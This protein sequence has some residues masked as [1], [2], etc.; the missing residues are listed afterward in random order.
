MS[1]T[2]TI[3]S[4]SK[5][6]AQTPKWSGRCFECGAWG[7]LLEEVKESTSGPKMVGKPNLAKPAEIIDL[8]LVKLADFPRAKTGIGEVDRVLGGGIVSGSLI[9]ISGE[10]GIGKSTLIAQI[11]NKLSGDVVYA[12]GEESAHQVKDRLIR[13]GC[14]LKKIKFIS[15]TNLNKIIAAIN[16]EEVDLLIIDS[17]QTVYTTDVEN[18]IG[19]INQIKAC[20]AKLMELAKKDNVPVVIVGHVTKDGAIAGPKNLEHM[21]D[22]VVY[23]ESDSGSDYRILR[24]HKNRFG[25]VNEVGIFEMTSEGF[26]EI[27]NPSMLFINEKQESLAGSVKSCIIE[28]TRPFLV[29]VQALV[30]K[31]SF[32]Y[33]QRK[34]SGFDLNRLQV[35]VAV[36]S[37][38]GGIN[39][40]SQD[41]ILNIVGGH[42]ISDQG[43]DLAVC[44]AIISS[45]KNRAISNETIVIGEVGLAGEVRKVMK[46]KERTE[47]AINLGFSRF[48]V[49]GDFNGKG[50]EIILA[51]KIADLVGMV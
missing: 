31:T 35:L 33:P 19:S 43:L 16:T 21:V 1:K 34:A 44:A 48:I 27:K 24:A 29:E 3:F 39:L 49:P 13:I 30:T 46:L 25:S 8:N 40:S 9:L 45:F 36:L 32:G 17:V 15:E 26:N 38:R 10:P 12:S 4:C 28:G 50:A 41:V 5:C 6:S 47:E 18:E 2:S 37:K 7:T 11:A 14:D 20:T 51:R 42:K 22:V 23:F